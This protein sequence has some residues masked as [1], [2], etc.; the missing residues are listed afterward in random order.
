MNGYVYISPVGVADP[1]EIPQE[2][3]PLHGTSWVLLPELGQAL[4]K[5][6]KEDDRS[7]IEDLEAM[8]F[9]DLPEMED[10]SVINEGIGKGSGYGF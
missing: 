4:R 10:I 5:L 2:S 7:V 6:E 1:E 9:T 8:N 3:A